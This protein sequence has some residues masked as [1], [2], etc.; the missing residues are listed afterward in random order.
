MWTQAKQGTEG[1]EKR[2]KEKEEKEASPLCCCFCVHRFRLS[3][4][5]DALC[6]RNSQSVKENVRGSRSLTQA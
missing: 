4:H 6:A 3:L 5:S 2:E 1:E